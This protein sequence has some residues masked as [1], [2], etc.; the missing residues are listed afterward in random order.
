M[1]VEK[2]K[3]LALRF[4]N[5]ESNRDSKCHTVDGL[6]STSPLLS[7]FLL[8]CYMRLTYYYGCYKCSTFNTQ[9]LYYLSLYILRV[10][11]KIFSV[12]STHSQLFLLKNFVKWLGLVMKLWL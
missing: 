11:N 1:K 8:E 9:R 3:V 4:T 10:G 7:K 6:F 12:P 2:I 5:E